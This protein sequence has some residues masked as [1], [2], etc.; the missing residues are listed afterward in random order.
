M[1]ENKLLHLAPLTTKKKSATSGRPRG[2]LGAVY[3]LL[4][5][6]ALT[7]TLDD[8]RQHI[9]ADSFEWESKK[10]SAADLYYSVSSHAS[11]AI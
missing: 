4:A 3:S 10:C 6:T 11:W 8:V 1:I 5:N 7:H 9:L 2:V